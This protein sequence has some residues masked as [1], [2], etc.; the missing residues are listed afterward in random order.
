MTATVNPDATAAERVDAALDIHPAGRRLRRGSVSFPRALAVSVGIQGPTAGVLAG[1]A[2]VASLVGGSGALAQVV[3]LAAMALVAYAF[4]RFTRRYNTASSVYA[5]NGSVF[6]PGYGFVSAALLLGV[7][8]GFAAGVYA[9][10]ADIAGPLLI[11]AGWSG[12]WVPFALAGAVAAIGL[13]YRSIGFSSLVVLILEGASILLI[14]VVGARVVATGGYHGHG[15][16]AAPFELH[17]VG[18]SVLA[19]GVVQVFGQFSGFEGA[20]TLGEEARRSTRTVPA[21]VA[22]S[23]AISAAVYI[24]FTW[25]AYSAFPTPAALAADPVPLVQIADT[26][27]SPT[28]GTAVNAAGL[29]SAFGAQ[30]ALVNAA[31]R[32][33]FALGR[34]FGLL[35]LTRISPRTGAPTGALT[36]VAVTTLAGLLAFAVEP[37]AGRAAQLLIQYGA[38]L[39][40]AA[41][42]L[43]VVAGWALAWREGRR[44][45]PLLVLTAGVALLGYLLYRSFRPLPAGALGWVAAAAVTTV[46]LAV[47]GSLLPGLRRALHGSPL[48]A[49][50]TAPRQRRA[51]AVAGVTGGS[52][53]GP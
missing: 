33:T 6:G 4:V 5:F 37:Q 20:A 25:V 36:V 46:A 42:L 28:V 27:L 26:Y 44:P 31:A 50:T 2:F 13:S 53:A 48:L 24:F 10:T 19:L 32:L 35:P 21:A 45:L 23:L 34:E 29:V 9:Y 12:G 51:G 41:Y 43:T 52:D 49:V 7:Y 47:V 22:W 15:L 1:P 40:I 8:L 14:A 18:L 39:L 38:Y 16:S 17:G 3:A 30:L 11:E